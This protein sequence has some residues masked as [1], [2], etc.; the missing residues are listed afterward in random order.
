MV[1]FAVALIGFG[2]VKG[3]SQVHAE[4]DAAIS[5]QTIQVAQ[6]KQHQ[7]EITTEVVTKYVDKIKLVHDQGETII[8]EVSHY[9]PSDTCILPAGF[10]LLHDAAASG[11]L[12]DATRS[13]DAQPVTA[14][15][16][17][18]T[19]ASN[20]QQSREIATQLESLQEWVRRQSSAR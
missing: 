17:A 15:D 4:W 7:A 19:I 11:E 12:P 18:S 1:L 10:R 20:Y 14:Q 9:V 16:V 6:V 3:A 13:A 5:K 2:W 8:K